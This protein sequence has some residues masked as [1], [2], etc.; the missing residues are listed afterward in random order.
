M[1][2]AWRSDARSIAQA[3]HSD[4][5]H[6]AIELTLGA[7]PS[8]AMRCV[9]VRHIVSRFA[10]DPSV[11]SPMAR[12]WIRKVSYSSAMR[13]PT[14]AACGGALRRLFDASHLWHLPKA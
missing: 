9:T 4:A 6:I 14:H 7:L 3:L 2:N 12:F 13:T 10:R 5:L 8:V 1:A 11:T